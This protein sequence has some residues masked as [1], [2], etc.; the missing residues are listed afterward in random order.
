MYRFS[1]TASLGSDLFRVFLPALFLLTL[2]TT[3]AYGQNTAILYHGVGSAPDDPYEVLN[4]EVWN[5]FRTELQLRG[6]PNDKSGMVLYGR[7]VSHP[8]NDAEML[9]M[10]ITEGMMLREAA[11]EAGAKNQ[12]WYAEQSA[13]EDA[14]E[15]SFVREYMTREILQNH[16]QVTNVVIRVFERSELEAT[17]SRYVDDL[18][19]RVS[20]RYPDECGQ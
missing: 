16:V 17:V 1:H 14:T 10:S 3:V 9:V 18:I 6:I 5:A 4:R 20:C 19:R 8:G 15:A 11:I 13:P 7:T 2:C 12:I